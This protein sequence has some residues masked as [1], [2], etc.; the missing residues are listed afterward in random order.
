MKPAFKTIL[1]S[2]VVCFSGAVLVCLGIET[3]G[4]T[5]MVLGGLGIILGPMAQDL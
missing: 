5:A 2:A 3:P 4:Y 1:G